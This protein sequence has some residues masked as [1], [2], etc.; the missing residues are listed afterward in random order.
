[1]AQ[2][3]FFVGIALV[4][5][6]VVVWIFR[7][8]QVSQFTIDMF[9]LRITVDSAALAVIACGI[10]L[11]WISTKVPPEPA[12]VV[13]SSEEKT[14][15][16]S[17]CVPNVLA[18]FRKPDMET[19]A[20]DNRPVARLSAISISILEECTPP[21]NRTYKSVMSYHFYSGKGSQGGDQ[22]VNLTF[23]GDN[24]APLAGDAFGLD[25]RRCIYGPG[26]D[27]SHTHDLGTLGPLV[28]DVEISIPP[29]GGTL[30]P[31]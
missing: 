12:R 5:I 19:H 28:K 14:V 9:G 18:V 23:R 2:T 3:A 27:R 24:G 31:C 13:K 7:P 29:A 1:M 22:N 20:G 26:E 8:G 10:A 4:A 30:T 16:P 17:A 21:A 6:G 15:A 25:L 11:V